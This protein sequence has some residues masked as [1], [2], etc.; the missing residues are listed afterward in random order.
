MPSVTNRGTV[1]KPLIARSRELVRQPSVRIARKVV[2]AVVGGT[3]VL[4]GIAMVGL[5]DRGFPNNKIGVCYRE[6]ITLK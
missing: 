6:T 1:K 2:V 5:E 3:A 4:V